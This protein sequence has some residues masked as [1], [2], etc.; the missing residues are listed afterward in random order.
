MEEEE[1]EEEEEEGMSIKLQPT[2][3]SMV[4]PVWSLFH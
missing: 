3:L 4:Y 2:K 1:E